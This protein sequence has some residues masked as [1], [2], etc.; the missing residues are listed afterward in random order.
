MSPSFSS[1]VEELLL[2]KEAEEAEKSN[3][4]G[5]SFQPN[6]GLQVKKR[7]KSGIGYG[8]GYGLGAAGGA[9]L[10][11]KYLS[12]LLPQP[13]SATTKAR[14]GKA[15]GVLGALSSF[16]TMEALRRANQVEQNAVKRNS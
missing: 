6:L 9:V 15:I 11:H 7:L 12:R 10:G 16:A 13:W 3:E 5:V 4:E 2:I 14:V 8:L 1:F